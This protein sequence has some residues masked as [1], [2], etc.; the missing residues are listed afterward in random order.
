MKRIRLFE[1]IGLVVILSLTAIACISSVGA[2][3]AGKLE[4]M[5]WVLKSYGD[6]NDLNT[7]V[8]DRETTLTF[9]K[10][11]K[12]VGGNGGVNSYGG[13]YK[14]D[15]DKL[16]INEII[17]TEMASTNEALNTQETQFF[18]ILQSAQSFKI[19]GEELTITG[20]EGGLVFTHK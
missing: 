3:N 19:T 14:I 10:D 12:R 6:P 1:L 13:D 2:D 9:D 11:T 5:T 17:H 7:A 15:G 20:T 8:A 16:T 18:K 4:G